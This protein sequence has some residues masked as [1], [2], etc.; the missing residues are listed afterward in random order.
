MEVQH[1]IEQGIAAAQANNQRT[2]YYYFYSATQADPTSEQAW[3]WRA[4]AA[5]Q[6]RDALFCLAAVLAL[7]PDNLV[8]RHGIEQI[9]AAVAAEGAPAALTI[10][11]SL[12][13]GEF[14]PPER[15][16][17]WQQA[18]QRELYD[19]ARVPRMQPVDAGELE[20]QPAPPVPVVRDTA[21]Y[22]RPRPAPGAGII[23]VVR[24]I[25]VDRDTQRV[26]FAIP[27]V[28]AVLL[29]IGA[30]AFIGV[31]ELSRP[32][33]AG[34]ATTPTAGAAAGLT[35]AARLTSVVT[36]TARAATP[37]VKPPTAVASLPT[38]LPP[39]AAPA[40]AVAIVPTLPPTAAPVPPTAVPVPPTAVSVP[41]TAVPVPP[42]P[43]PVPP[44]PVPAGPKMVTVGNGQTLQRVAQQEGVTLG[45]LM[46][47]NNLTNP[48]DA[49]AGQQLKVP[50]ADYKPASLKYTIR[51]G[52]NLST[53][54]VLFGI[55]VDSIAQ[56]NDI[57]NP[58]EMD[59]GQTIEI[60]LQ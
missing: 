13:S 60:P 31:N 8:A 33:V 42:T 38:L 26:Q 2:A 12:S 51:P 50:A 28:I 17:E 34:A 14:K 5:P 19:M 54:A 56:R 32:T 10:T 37:V 41:P 15:R 48:R 6:P 27:V 46:A 52:E 1:A 7:N 45:A 20:R 49:G 23:G 22:R 3:L 39:T 25:L 35:A 53:I 40:T 24:R 59:A 29:V 57:A 4:S 47:F 36:T 9:S 18:F 30:V 58:S 55:S 21:A 11:P 44:T 16:L 43:V